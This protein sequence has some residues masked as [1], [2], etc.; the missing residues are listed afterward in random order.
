MA[1]KIATGAQ[2]F[3]FLLENNAFYIDKTHFIKEWWESLASITLITRPRRFGK[4]LTLDTVRTFF[5][6]EFATRKELFENLSIWK[7]EKFRRLQGKIPVIYISFSDIKCNNIE[8]T[9]YFIKYSI[10]NVYEAYRFLL[11]DHNFFSQFERERFLAV[12]SSMSDDLTQIA[13]K[14]LSKYL[15][16]FYGV[17]PLIL[18]DEYDTPM[19]EA[20]S[21]HYWEELSNFMRGFFNSTFKTNPYIER[22]LITGITRISHESLF[23]DLNNLEIISSTSR[24]YADCF[25]FTE[26]EVFSAMDEFCLPEKQKVKKW[27]DGF[28]FGDIHD[29]YNPW[30]ITQYL[31]KKRFRPYWA[32]T[33]SNTM[34]TDII[35]QSNTEVKR[36][37]EFLLNGNSITVVF[38]EEIIFSQLRSNTGSIWALLLAAGYVK[39]LS[40]KDEISEYEITLTNHEVS[41]IFENNIK[42]WFNK[43]A[44]SSLTS[45]FYQALLQADLPQINSTIQRISLESFSW[46]DTSGKEPERFYHAFVLG[47]LVDLKASYAL[48]SNRES[49]KGRYDIMLTPKDPAQHPGIVIEFKSMDPLGEKDLAGSAK[50]ALDQIRSLSYVAS[51]TARGV[52][53]DQILAYGFAFKGKEVLVEGGKAC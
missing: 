13:L 18:I 16:R 23:S 45:D 33:S 49:G 6:P 39:V 14:E 15:K 4:T 19:Q 48:E 40:Y 53:A 46:F 21:Q 32:N 12:N 50:A 34:V 9:K 5:S 20:W 31:D 37:T 47:M 28:I 22:G 52:P 41:L 2:S 10:E 42:E 7:Y 17:N 36:L 3:S 29:I 38:N 43:P 44:L 1:R 11:D 30:S 35:G 25:G 8:R 27:Y 24:Q 51:L 26:E